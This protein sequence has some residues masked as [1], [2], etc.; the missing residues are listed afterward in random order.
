MRVTQALERVRQMKPRLL[1]LSRRADQPLSAQHLPALCRGPLDKHAS[2]TQPER[3]TSVGEAAHTCG[4]VA[5]RVAHPSS[6]AQCSLRR[7]ALKVGAVCGNPDLCW[8]DRIGPY[9]V[10][11]TL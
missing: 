3:S 7:Q 6:L 1:C 4:R 10:R 9:R 8:G 11:W 2:A 5:A